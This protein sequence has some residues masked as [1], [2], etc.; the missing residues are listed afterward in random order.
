MAIFRT[1]PYVGPAR[2]L[3]NAGDKTLRTK[4]LSVADI[5]AWKDT[6]PSDP[7]V[8]TFVVDC[9]LRFWIADRR[10][11]H[12]ACARRQPVLAAGEVTFDTTE[13]LEPILAI[14]N[15]STG[16]CPDL[17]CIDA[18]HASLHETGWRLPDRFDPASEFRRCNCN[19]IVIV[20]DGD[21]SC[22]VC[23]D[24]LS[25]SYNVRPLP[26]D[27]LGVAPE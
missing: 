2:F 10:S 24:E 21:F 13:Q 18:V 7:S 27:N 11:E 19:Q 15:Q 25:R 4:I 6:D 22:P 3:K 17:T 8:A 12:V 5:E 26:T 16:Y 23:G 20:K 1:Y 14:S 9:D